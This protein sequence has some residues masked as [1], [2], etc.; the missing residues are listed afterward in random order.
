LHPQFDT[1]FAE[2]K[3][4]ETEDLGLQLSG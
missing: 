1:K 3:A 2:N 4:L